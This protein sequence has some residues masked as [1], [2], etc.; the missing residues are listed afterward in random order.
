M[1]G[2]ESY[3][4]TIPDGSYY[5]EI[6]TAAVSMIYQ[7]L[8]ML[9]NDVFGFEFYQHA[10][11]ASR[12]ETI[13][14]R[15]GLP[16]PVSAG[17]RPADTYARQVLRGWSTILAGGS[18]STGGHTS[19]TGTTDATTV[20]YNSL[21]IS[22]VFQNWAKFSGTHTVPSTFAG[23][24]NF[25]LY[26]VSPTSGMAN[27]VD[28]FTVNMKPLVDMGGS[29]DRS[30]AEGANPTGIKI[31]IN[32][33]I[34]ANTKLVL[35]RNVANPGDAISDTDFT[36]GTV[37]AGVYGNATVTHTAGSDIWVIAVPAGNYDGGKVAA[38]NQSGLTIPVNF[39]SD[40]VAESTEYA[41]FEI[42]NP[43]ENGAS[44]STMWT[45]AAPTCDG[46][47]KNDG[48]V[49]S[50]TDVAGTA[51]RTPTASMTLTASKTYT[52]TQTPGPG[53]PSVTSA[54]TD[55]ASPTD[56]ET[57][58]PAS[59]DTP[60]HTETP[61]ASGDTPTPGSADT[62]TPTS[63]PTITP[64][65]AGQYIVFASPPARTEDGPA[66]TLT[67]TSN[68]GLPVT[69]VST[70]PTICRV[71]LAGVVTIVAPGSCEI[72]ASA[73]GGTVGGVVYGA[74]P[75]VT[76]TITIRG[77][78]SISFATPAS[79]LYTAPDF[80][81]TATASST[82]A[83][84]YSSRSA[85]V[86]TVSRSGLVDVR[87]P[88]VCSITATQSGGT[89]AGIEYVAATPVTVSFTVNALPQ[90]ITF[91][92]VGEKLAYQGDVDVHANASSGLDVVFSSSTPS[93]CSVIGKRVK[94]LSIGKC[95]ITATQPG[96]LK[97]GV[98][99]AAATPITREFFFVDS[100]ATIT[101]TP[102]NTST[103]TPTN[104]PSPVPFL[105]KKGAVGASFVLGLLQNDTLVTWGMN[106]EYQANIPPCCGSGIQDIAVGTNF[107]LALKGGRVFGWGANTLGQLKFP[108]ATGK[109]I[110]AIA[111]GGAHGLAL[112]QK[113][114]V[115]AWGDNGFKQAQVPKGLK[116]VKSMAGGGSH[117]VVLMMDGTLSAWGSNSS[118]QAKPPFG[119]KSITEV[120]AGLD[121][122]LAL[123]SDGSVIAWGNN[124]YGQA[125][126]PTNATDIKQVSAGTQF[127]MAVKNNGDVIA[128]GRNDYNQTYIPPE[129]TDIYSVA[130][131]YANTIL[132]L[133]SGRI[134]VLGS[135]TDGVD[136]SRTPT[137]T[138]TPTP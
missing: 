38:N 4:T 5:A 123:K 8:C 7:P 82:L 14:V 72:T 83:V 69:Y 97:S 113:G 103:V 50:I 19:Y 46:S 52:R 47:F 102:T 29:I 58:T 94:Y 35:R 80:S 39:R 2:A 43:G 71:T 60:T 9:N 127:S 33:R 57:P 131:G 98:I 106:R 81:L 26:S 124:S 137:K 56:T 121:H 89:S 128:W 120:A 63:I 100:T 30:A 51:T 6:S 130:A 28:R 96:G 25:G 22:P 104:T 78:Q 42:A 65:P 13:E 1:P 64:T 55:T 134:V 40:A 36:I 3:I 122:S 59:S 79:R 48:V 132:G 114:F 67:A 105:M 74:A 84:S 49:Y 61:I 54:P 27:L 18:L 133:R 32:G 73:A 86:C 125:T 112:T 41:Y 87:A 44:A 68:L 15:F 126:I 107:A 11:W 76:R 17:Y 21:D 77:K 70:T 118:N 129:Y 23:V 12:A 75:D 99:Y 117:T 16:T 95:T 62:A 119:L 92:P 138:A 135:Q 24:K 10:R 93:V 31:R 109:D 37:T 53:T 116:R 110:T 108:P 20:L 66:F 101:T 91:A 45:Y 90:T 136:V 115:I 88:G 111:A 34:A 85:K